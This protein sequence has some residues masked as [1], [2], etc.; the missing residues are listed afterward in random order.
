MIYLLDRNLCIYCKE[1][2]K[3][4]G[5]L[6]STCQRKL[7]KIHGRK[8][9]GD[10]ECFFPYLYLGD[11]K[12]ILYQYKFRRKIYYKHFLANSLLKGLE[13]I[14][15]DLLVPIP[16]TKR[17]LNFR[18]FQQVEEICKI[19]T[20]KTE[21]PTILALEKTKHTKDQHLITLKERENNLKDV[22]SLV[23]NIKDK[24]VLLVDDITTTGIT[25]LEAAN[26]L[27]KGNPKSIKFLAIA[28]TNPKDC[29]L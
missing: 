19:L 20:K 1:E 29:E 24:E 16:L 2:E 28:G 13:K 22:F 4:K 23:N 7:K 15:P 5:D 10:Y 14:K 26:E 6:C 12:N 9:L 18:G 21:V 3:S 17:K 27:E 8:F 11:I 25:F